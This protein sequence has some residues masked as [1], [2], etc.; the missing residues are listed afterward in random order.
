TVTSLARPVNKHGDA[1]EKEEPPRALPRPPGTRR[2]E[3]AL[4]GRPPALSSI[5]RKRGGPVSDE[6]SHAH[7]GESRELDELRAHAQM[8]E[9]ELQSLRRRVQ[10]APKRVRTLEE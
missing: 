5:P 2:A 8:L 4:I 10:E 1:R 7:G 6:H 9:E 3:A